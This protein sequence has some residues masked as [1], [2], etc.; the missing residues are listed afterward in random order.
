MVGSVS[1]REDPEGHGRV[2]AIVPIKGEK[3]ETDWLWRAVYCADLSLPVPDVGD[4][5]VFFYRDGDPHIGVYLAVQNNKL[6]PA[7]GLDDY[8]LTLRGKL[9]VTIGKITITADP[10][11]T[12]AI[13]G[14][15]SVYINDPLKQVTTLGAED[16]DTEANG[17]DK[18]VTK[19]W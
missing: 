11:G 7:K 19:G 8:E 12:L 9:K 2:K 16:N 17:A 10:G 4:T 3:Q 18:L 6:N 14:A 5:V 15:T 1:D 13:T